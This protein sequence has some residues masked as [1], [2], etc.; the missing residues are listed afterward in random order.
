MLGARNRVVLFSI[1]LNGARD[2]FNGEGGNPV[3]YGTVVL[4]NALR[5]D[6]KRV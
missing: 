4:N 2:Q 6:F 3:L 1:A 5:E